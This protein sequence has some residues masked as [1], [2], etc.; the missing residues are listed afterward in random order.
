MPAAN[1]VTEYGAVSASLEEELKGSDL[2]EIQDR[3]EIIVAA[4]EQEGSMPAHKWNDSS[5]QTGF[6]GGTWLFGEMTLANNTTKVI[7]STSAYLN[8]WADMRVVTVAAAAD[9]PSGANHDPT[10][11]ILTAGHTLFDTKS[12][13]AAAGGFGAA[14]SAWNHSGNLWLFADSANAGLSARNDG[15]GGAIYF[16]W[17]I[18]MTGPSR[19]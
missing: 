14:D 4:S 17:L 3:T 7:D 18:L 15:A 2:N 16:Y 19:Y 10:N 1:Y 6:A 11:N 12:G 9:L 8:C 5:G 13:A